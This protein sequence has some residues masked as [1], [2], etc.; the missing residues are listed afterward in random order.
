MCLQLLFVEKYEYV[1]YVDSYS[2]LSLRKGKKVIKCTLGV[3]ILDRKLPFRKRSQ[4]I[5]TLC[6]M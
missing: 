1:T 6:S 3:G 2:Q 5:K 4:T